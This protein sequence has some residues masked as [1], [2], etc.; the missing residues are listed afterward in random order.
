MTPINTLLLP[1]NL[2]SINWT[3]SGKAESSGRAMIFCQGKS[4]EV[5]VLEYFDLVELPSDL[6]LALLWM[7]AARQI[8]VP[9]SYLDIYA[10]S[11]SRVLYRASLDIFCPFRSS[12]RTKAV[13]ASSGEI[14]AF[15]IRHLTSSHTSNLSLSSSSVDSSKYEIY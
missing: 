10:S 5:A 13:T 6:S 4:F 11:R 14:T 8:R 7:L 3:P 2:R 9:H 12:S 15:R 1:E